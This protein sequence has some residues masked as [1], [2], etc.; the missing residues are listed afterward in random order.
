MINYS[1]S[2]KSITIEAL[3]EIISGQFLVHNDCFGVVSGSAQKGETTELFVE[4]VFELDKAKEEIKNC[5]KV[6]W[7]DV[8]RVVT[9]KPDPGGKFKLI[10]IST[11]FAPSADLKAFVRLNG[12]FI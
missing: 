9:G 7:D 11:A 6:Y 2:G 10:G 4:E 3:E 12:V 5:T 1:Y 8:N